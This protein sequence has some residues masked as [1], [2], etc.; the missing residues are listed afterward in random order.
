M[1]I[2]KKLFNTPKAHTPFVLVPP[3]TASKQTLNVAYSEEEADLQVIANSGISFGTTSKVII[4]EDQNTHNIKQANSYLVGSAKKVVSSLDQ[5]AGVCVFCEKETIKKLKNISDD[6]AR[7]LALVD[8]ESAIRCQNCNC[9]ICISHSKLVEI[10]G[11]RLHVCPKCHNKFKPKFGWL[12]VLF[13]FL[14]SGLITLFS[15]DSSRGGSHE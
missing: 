2:L 8:I 6:E 9:L 5:I 13:A 14:F 1:N 3:G 15:E 4:D 12:K 7:L 11:Q 10:D